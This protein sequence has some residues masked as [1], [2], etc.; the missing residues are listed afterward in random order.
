MDSNTDQSVAH[1][2]VFVGDLLRKGGVL[3][4][5]R[6]EGK[7]P[8]ATAKALKIGRASVHRRLQA[9]RPLQLI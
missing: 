1:G 4:V 6:I 8:S 3:M 5:T 2:G 7:G 9:S